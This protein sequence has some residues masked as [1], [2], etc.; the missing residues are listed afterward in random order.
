MAAS[1]VPG[2]SAAHAGPS[3]LDPAWGSN[4]IAPL[5]SFAND[6]ISVAGGTF[7]VG[8]ADGRTAVV[9]LD[10]QGAPLTTFGSNGRVVLPEP[11]SPSGAR[12]AMGEGRL[13]TDSRGRIIVL[14]NVYYYGTSDWIGYELFRLTPA[15]AMDPTFD[16]DGQLSVRR[17]EGAY[18]F[19]GKDLGVGLQD[20]VLVTVE[21]AF[22]GTAG[23]SG[24]LQRWTSTGAVDTSFAGGTVMVNS[25]SGTVRA[26]AVEPSG[27]V[28]VEDGDGLVAVQPDGT[29]D[30]SFGTHGRVGT[31]PESGFWRLTDG[32]LIIA[33]QGYADAPARISAYTTE[34]VEETTF[35]DQG[36]LGFVPA[37]CGLTVSVSDIAQEI[38]G[39]LVLLVLDSCDDGWISHLYRVSLDG[40]WLDVLPDDVDPARPVELWRLTAAAD[41]SVL[42]SGLQRTG[43]GSPRSVIA[44]LIPDVAERAS[45]FTALDTP[46]RLL[47]TRIGLGAPTARLGAQQS[48]R[49]KVAGAGGVAPDASAVVLNVTAVD[50]TAD[51]YVTVSPSGGARPLASNLNVRPGTIRPN[52][53]TVK[54][55]NGGSIDIYNSTG[56]M[57]LVVD[58]SGFYR[59]GAGSGFTELS[60][61]TRILDTR[62]G[63]GSP[64]VPVTAMA[65]LRVQVRGT[66]VVPADAT[67]VV[68]NVTAVLPNASTYVTVWPGGT[69]R[70]ATSS[71]NLGAGEIAPNLVTVKIGDDGTVAL[72][73]GPGA[74]HLVADV[75]GWYGP[76]GDTWFVPLDPIRLLDTREG[77]GVPLPADGTQSAYMEL[78][79]VPWSATSVVLNL[80]AV[81]PTTAS[82]LTAYPSGAP[83]P[84]ASNL[85]VTAGL[86]VPN[87]A[88]VGI[89]NDGQVDLYNRA[90]A[91]HVIADVA[92]YFTWQLPST[93]SV[94]G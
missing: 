18:S 91:T 52:A 27:R 36:T 89:G 13:A 47:D 93:R 28:I 66:A 88:I 41:G 23:R 22:P 32:T 40:E 75:A 25:N 24:L 92:G 20:E 2:M 9:G 80:T 38:G 90:G 86:T 81:N 15:G 35:G 60:A 54:V 48:L 43:P 73:P 39:D 8:W 76:Q 3:G 4:G 87:L 6:V 30:A 33:R 83:R 82:F 26:L 55:G 85:N 5:P 44:K 7:A 94:A 78:G 53:V 42:A 74:V 16:R 72:A 59:V 69:V 11:P 1:V 29:L 17:P 34:G 68:M 84:V 63:W 19:F 50:P 56:T 79:G 21:R 62:E 31:G 67:A 64:A 10:G 49:L 45:G 70:P 46:T 61:P 57:D 12:V 77:A 58:V 51:A 71:L 37:E 65:P 14:E